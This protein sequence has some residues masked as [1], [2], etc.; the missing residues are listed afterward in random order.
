MEKCTAV[1]AV[2]NPL[3]GQKGQ[4]YPLMPV[5]LTKDHV[6]NDVEELEVMVSLD[7]CT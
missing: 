1:L 4:G 3:F 6:L 5:Q 2:T 7:L